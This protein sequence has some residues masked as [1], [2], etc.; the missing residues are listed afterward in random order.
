MKTSE[1]NVP[2]EALHIAQ[3]ELNERNGSLAHHFITFLHLHLEI[4]A[5]KNIARSINSFPCFL[6]L[7]PLKYLLGRFRLFTGFRKPLVKQYCPN[8]YSG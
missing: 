5:M 3:Y 4:N 6:E 2:N 7:K 8:T 1:D